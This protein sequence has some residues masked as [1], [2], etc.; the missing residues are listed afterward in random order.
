MPAICPAPL[1]RK[2]G[3]H[4]VNAARCVFL[5]GIRFPTN[6]DAH[7]TEINFQ[8][9]SGKIQVYNSIIL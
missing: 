7:L 6:C 4:P 5:I 1:C 2:F 3:P 8:T 9:R